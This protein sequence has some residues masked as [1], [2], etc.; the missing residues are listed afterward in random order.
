[1]ASL[2]LPV[3]RIPH[4]SSGDDALGAALKERVV[5]ALETGAVAPMAVVCR[6]A[7]IDLVPVYHLRERHIAVD[8]FLASMSRV[9]SE[10]DDVLAVGLAGRFRARL[11]G[12]GAK[13]APVALVFLE[14]TDCR[15]WLWRSLI[16]PDGH[17]V[18]AAGETFRA[19]DG[20]PLPAGLGR[21]W[22]IGRR[23][24]LTVRFSVD[25]QADA[26]EKTAAKVH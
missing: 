15:W 6:H 22:S 16:D 13:R 14:W 24:R 25:E 1:M 7:H 21:W 4:A 20:D 8:A 26:D 3:Q 18:E 12:T 9:V 5:G 10:S 2:R 11:P 17:L 23:R 19:V